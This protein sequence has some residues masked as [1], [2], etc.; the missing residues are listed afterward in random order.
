MKPLRRNESSRGRAGSA[1]IRWHR[2]V[3]L[4]LA[5]VFLVVV[6]TGLFLNHAES[7]DLR[8]K[9]FTASWL[10]DWYDMVP[11]NPPVSFRTGDDWIVSLDSSVFFN[12]GI[13][14]EMAPL[15]GVA[16]T[17]D[18]HLA[19]SP[20]EVVLISPDGELVERL[21]RASLPPG[22]VEKIGTRADAGSV[23]VVLQTT[24]GSFVFG[25]DFLDWTELGLAEA[26]AIEWSSPSPLPR[27]L[28]DRI[29]NVYRGSGVSVHRV[30]LDLH[31]GRF[32]GDFGVIL[33]DI[34][35]IGLLVLIFTGLWYAVRVRPIAR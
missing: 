20:G 29:L 17:S 12:D 31:S 1:V 32:F 13:V 2:R 14:S 10:L 24:D 6:V 18:M 5:A 34:A 11:R 9:R 35:A 16:S 22:S 15:V 25:A 8:A 7:L 26:K 19:A 3:G 23:S 27:E 4:S 30:I 28:E 33:V 21:V